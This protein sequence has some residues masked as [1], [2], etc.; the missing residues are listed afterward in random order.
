MAVT[1]PFTIF[2][3]YWVQKFYLRT[4]R[5]IRLLDLE[6]RSPVY[7]H[8]TETLEGLA[9]LR[10]FH[11]QDWFENIAIDKIDDSQKPYYLMTCIQRWLSLVLGLVIAILAVILMAFALC[12]TTSSNGGSLGVALTTMLNLNNSLQAIITS[13]TQAET[14]IAGISRTKSFQETTENENSMDNPTIPDDTWPNGDIEIS[15]L[16]VKYGYF[17]LQVILYQIK[18]KI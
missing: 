16:S 5:Q 3:L 2:I 9:T 18:I 6:A 11:W 1:I 4:S 14:S 15:G 10:A 7:Q 13:W 8:F 12:I 17:M